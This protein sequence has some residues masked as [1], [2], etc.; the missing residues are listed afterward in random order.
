M[1]RKTMMLLC[2]SGLSLLP[3]CAMQ[4][5]SQAETWR[6]PKDGMQFVWVPAGSFLAEIPATLKDPNNPGKTVPKRV[7]FEQGFWLGQTE[8]TVG[9]FRR[10]V[11]Q[12]GYVT[13]AEKSASRFT[14]KSPGFPQADNHPVVYLSHDD[15]VQYAVWAGVDLPT[16]AE[17]V[18]ACRAGTTT[19][20]YWGDDMD[21]RYA[22]HRCN[23]DGTGTRPV[24]SKLPNSWGL[25]DM[26]GNA[27]EYC[28]V[29]ESCFA[30]RGGAWTRCLT[31]RNRQDK[32]TGNMLIETV[33]PKLQECDPHPQF[34]PY[35][36]DDDRGFR[37]IRRTGP[38]GKSLLEPS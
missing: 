6:N 27:W 30:S 29:G 3:A 33:E 23:T 35:P 37:C 20:F 16:E 8:V 19:T 36:W 18:Y 22:W 2:I 13:D 31:Y 25:Y 12:T 7:T 17:W 14:W 24:G 10:F 38:A 32:M 15:A 21:D 9:Q 4:S 34:P 26:V 28:R 11:K 5:H 1:I